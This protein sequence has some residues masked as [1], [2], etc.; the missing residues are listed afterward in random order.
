MKDRTSAAQ[1]PDGKVQHVQLLF[2]QHDQERF[3]ED[4]R[5]P[6]ASIEIE[7]TCIEGAPESRRLLRFSG[8]QALRRFDERVADLFHNLL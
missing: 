1:A 3:D 5:L 2:R 8:L 7:M 6:Q 4:E